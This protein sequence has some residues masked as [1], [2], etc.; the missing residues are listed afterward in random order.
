MARLKS[1]LRIFFHILRKKES[2]AFQAYDRYCHMNNLN[3]V[4]GII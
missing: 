3:G 2:N 1:R 4:F